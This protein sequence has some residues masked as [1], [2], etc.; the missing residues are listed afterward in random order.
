MISVVIPVF[1]EEDNINPLYGELKEI[2]AKLPENFEIIFID[3]G[4][5][6]KTLTNLLNLYSKEENFHIIQFVEHFGKSAALTAGFK[7]ATG[8]IIVTLDGDGQDIPSNI[9]L[10]LS[11]LT[12]DYD[13][14][15]GWRYKRQDS[16]IKK[17]YSKAYNILSNIFSGIDIHDNNCML[18][19]YRKE[20]VSDLTLIKGAHRYLPTI[21][22]S[23]GN[24]ISEVKVSHRQR[25]S[26]KS[27]YGTKRLFKGFFDLLKFN[28]FWRKNY[29]EKT[30]KKNIY[31]I[32][33]MYGFL[34]P[35]TS[36]RKL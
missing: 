6:D 34:S 26:G 3:D 12:E 33:K 9:P 15:C 16:G 29:E 1:N 23:R 8:E 17:F 28:F 36:D 20:V 11:S 19:A 7:H 30:K 18:R 10:L 14:I 35:T 24:R 5:T 13:V 21:I 27:K 25:L 32:E 4:S 2:L 31:E 22:A